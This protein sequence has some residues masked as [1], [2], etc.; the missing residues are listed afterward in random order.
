[1]C[2]ISGTQERAPSLSLGPE[3]YVITDSNK[4]YIVRNGKELNYL[5]YLPTKQKMRNISGTQ[6]RAPSVFF[7]PESYV[8]T[9]SNKPYIVRNGKELNYLD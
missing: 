7:G 9:D 4:P 3:S 1:M 5:D 2:N 8:I 6:E